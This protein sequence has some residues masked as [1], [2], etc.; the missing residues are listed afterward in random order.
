MSTKIGPM[1]R[2]PSTR[3]PSGSGITLAWVSSN[4]MPR[5][6]II[7]PSV[8][9]SGLMPSTTTMKPLS[10]PKA[11]PLSRVTEN[12]AT[13]FQ[14]SRVISNTP[15]ELDRKAIEPSE[16]SRLPVITTI[17]M[18]QEMITTDAIVCSMAT[19]LP[20]SRKCDVAR[21]K[22]T[23]IAASTSTKPQSSSNRAKRD[24]GK[25]HSADPRR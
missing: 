5:S 22:K 4:P 16:M 21:L 24:R 6:V 20:N 25:F 9:I 15:I 3:T 17:A 1:A 23:K 2:L 11:T 10:M 7:V 19:M 12:A 13:G 8:V 18:P 14:P